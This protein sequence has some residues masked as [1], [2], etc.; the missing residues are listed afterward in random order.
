MK[1]LIAIVLCAAAVLSLAACA[2]KNEPVET[3]PIANMVNPFVDYE[4]LEAAEEAAGFELE[5]PDSINGFPDK[6]IQVMS[7]KMIQV[8][9]LNG[10]DRLIIRKQAGDEDIS[11][12]YGEYSRIVSID[13]DG[14]TVTIRGD[15]DL[16]H[17]ALWTS[18]G[19]SYAIMADTPIKEADMSALVSQ[20]K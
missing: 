14:R 18:D 3:E 7:G 20:V 15:G 17:T 6:L 10:D 8:M 1:K 11:G 2:Q 19:Y 13:I 9:F 16:I 5:A 12:D 4:T